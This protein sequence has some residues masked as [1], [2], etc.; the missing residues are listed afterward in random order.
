LDNF[1]EEGHMTE[2]NKEV[3]RLARVSQDRA[4]RLRTEVGEG[5][6]WKVGTFI[7]VAMILAVLVLA[8]AR[9]AGA[10][11]TT[12]ACEHRVSHRLVREAKRRAIRPYLGWLHLTG[13][14]ESGGW[15]LESGLRAYNPAGPFYGRYQFSASTWWATGAHVWV[16]AADGLEQAF[17]AV[18]WRERIGNPHQAAGWPVC[19]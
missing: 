4:D 2:S 18:R 10:S 16:Y 1:D 8:I 6:G 11:C 19:G 13:A 14:C 12:K 15:S 3:A 7:L 5:R 17:R 9:V